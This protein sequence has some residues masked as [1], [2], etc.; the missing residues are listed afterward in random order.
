[1]VAHVLSNGR[2]RLYILILTPALAMVF[3]ILKQTHVFAHAGHGNEEIGEF[4][5][6]A[7]RIVTSETAK[8]I[9]LKVEEVSNSRLE[10]VL[11]ISGVVRPN[12]DKHRAVVSRVP[13]KLV[14]VHV[15][16]GA[17]VKKGDLLA[18]IDSP[19]LA[20]SQ[21][22]VRK[23]E[24]DYAKLLLD[25]DRRLGDADRLQAESESLVGQIEV[26]KKDY[27]RS[28]SVSG[29]VVALRDVESRKSLVV[30]LEGEL[31]SKRVE[32]DIAKRDSEGLRRQAEALK[33]SRAAMLAIHNIDPASSETQP[34]G[35]SFS[36]FADL[37]GIVIERGAVPGS[38]LQPSDPILTVADFSSVQVEGEL[39]ESL[40]SRVE[41]RTG[42]NVRVRPVSDP[43][44]V[45][46]GKV[47]FIA[48]QLE[49]VKRTA[50]L[51]V[52]VP[53]PDGV[54]RGEMWVNLA[55]VLSEKKDALVV[56]KSAVVV[57]GPVHFVFVEIESEDPKTSQPAK[58]QKH[59]IEPGLSNDLFVEV[60]DG[61]F[62]GDRVVSQGAYSLT[63]LRPKAKAKTTTTSDA[64]KAPE[65]S[66]DHSHAH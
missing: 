55:I 32:I 66:D 5:I 33:L 49:P 58:Y 16:V 65:K 21:Y 57:D 24:V 20:R 45:L 11:E 44:T 6:D 48:P 23:L 35:S 22:E 47:K 56:P 17:V 15:Q 42:E 60:K 10:D 59:D 19:E 27:E 28:A 64:A 61:V 52:D 50:H 14:A 41:K 9:G 8:H 62:P 30:K 13:G 46:R 25:V 26:A 2:L 40:I 38:W 31:K 7:P 1:M 51:I 34:I 3:A 4:D 18:E 12:P 53:N 63:Q 43:T 36:I 29:E 39:P 54:L 37:D